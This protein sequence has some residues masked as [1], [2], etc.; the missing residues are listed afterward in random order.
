[1]LWLNGIALLVHVLFRPSPALLW[2]PLFA[3]IFGVS[4]LGVDTWFVFKDDPAALASAIE[5][6]LRRV[7]IEFSRDPS[8]YHLSL[9]GRTAS[10]RLHPIVPGFLALTFRGNWKD[11]R[12]RVARRFLRK[13]GEP[14]F[15][16]LRFRV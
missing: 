11:N 1:V 5:T 8:G 9:G 2:V 6:R 16:R 15:P 12:A 10:I 14:L 4:W 3:I 7:L 13:Y